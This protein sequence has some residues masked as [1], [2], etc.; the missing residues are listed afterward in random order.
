MVDSVAHTFA[1][2]PIVVAADEGWN[3]IER[4]RD[5]V[6]LGQN[7]LASDDRPAKVSLESLVLLQRSF[8]WKASHTNVFDSLVRIVHQQIRT[9]SFDGQTSPKRDLSSPSPWSIDPVGRGAKF[10]SAT[11]EYKKS[12]TKFN[13]TQLF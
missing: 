9:L 3:T 6:L 10:R 7:N 5:I 11:I 12:A 13:R 2:R 8:P 1:V 4:G